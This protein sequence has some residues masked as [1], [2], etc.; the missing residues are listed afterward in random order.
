[1]SHL[2]VSVLCIIIDRENY[3]NVYISEFDSLT[4]VPN[5]MSRFMLSVLSLL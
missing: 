3:N 1:M 2:V 4:L 5:T